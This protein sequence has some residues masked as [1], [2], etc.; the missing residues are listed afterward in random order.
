MKMM[1]L[2]NEVIALSD[3]SKLNAILLRKKKVLLAV[4]FAESH[5][6]IDN[7][8]KQLILQLLR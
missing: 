7:K 2:A 8:E 3:E 1:T 6:S 4:S 5:N